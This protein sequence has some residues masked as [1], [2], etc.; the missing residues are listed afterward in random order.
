MNLTGTGFQ[1]WPLTTG[2]NDDPTLTP[3]KPTSFNCN[4]VPDRCPTGPLAYYMPGIEVTFSGTITQP[5]EGGSVI[6][7][8]AFYAALFDSLDW[9]QCWHGNQVSANYVKGVDWLPIEYNAMGFR[10]PTRMRSLIALAG[11]GAYPFETTIFV[12]ACSMFG[13][14]SLETMQ[15]ALLFRNSQLKVNAASASVLDGLSTGAVFT[16]GVSARASAVLV[17]RQDLVLGPAVEWVLSQIVA[18]NNSTQVQI[19]NFGTD[20]QMQGVEP[21]G[22]VITLMELSSVLAQEGVFA[23]ENVTQFQFPWRGQQVT[24]HMQAL[25]SQIITGMPND[26][27]QAFGSTALNA[28]TDLTGYP[29]TMANAP[30]AGDSPNDDFRAMYGWI[31]AQGA[32]DLD[33]TSLQ[34]ADTP[35]SYFLTVTGGFST[36]SH[37]VLQQFARSWQPAMVANWLQQITAGGNSSLAAYC[38][39]GGLSKA[40][41]HR[42]TPR[43]KHII[44]ADQTRYLPWQFA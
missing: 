19:Q 12:P 38:L 31:M 2:N 7:Q 42:R 37:Q 43:S 39:Q 35:Q 18:G 27:P 40:Q 26:R 36:G 25:V 32:D 33:L 1:V 34:T 28:N 14:L 29:Y 20:T 3:G 24:Q 44:T 30:V 13:R 11:A 9:I 17:P 8:D 21:G 23:T 22:G 16:G 15:L 6:F 41:L 5:S 4:T 10:H